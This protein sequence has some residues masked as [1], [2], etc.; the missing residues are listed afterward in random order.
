MDT[1]YCKGT[2]GSI[3]PYRN[4][5]AG[6]C[7]CC[8]IPAYIMQARTVTELNKGLGQGVLAS[9]SLV[10]PYLHLKTIFQV[11]TL[12]PYFSMPILPSS[13]PLLLSNAILISII[14]LLNYHSFPSWIPSISP[15]LFTPPPPL[16]H[17]IPPLLLQAT[18]SHSPLH[19]SISPTYIHSVNHLSFV[20]SVNHV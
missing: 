6:N 18:M 13:L 16:H 3:K 17:F 14:S 10:L 20:P 11:Y 1:S 2:Q 15:P 8:S 5:R 9:P 12:S 19:P 4:R 7:Q